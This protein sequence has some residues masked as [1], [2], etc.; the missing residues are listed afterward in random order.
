MPKQK[1]LHKCISKL[2]CFRLS[3]EPLLPHDNGVFLSCYCDPMITKHIGGQLSEAE[4]QMSFD[5]SLSSN[6]KEFK[7]FTWVI[8]EKRTETSVGICALVADS[9]NK[10]IADIG[11]ILL[12]D[13]QRAGYASEALGKLIDF[14]FQQLRLTSIQG[15]SVL[16]N[17]GSLKLMLGLGFE[18][19]REEEL[20]PVGN[21]WTL[22]SKA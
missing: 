2:D 10:N 16:E 7:R 21:Y 13:F 4:A 1:F 3:L 5:L 9:R 8:K 17:I 20:Q 15:Y 19:R 14:G 6:K 11:A 18:L 22:R 12:T